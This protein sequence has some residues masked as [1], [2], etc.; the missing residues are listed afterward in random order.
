MNSLNRSVLRRYASTTARAIVYG[1]YG[2]PL[3]CIKVLRH[4]LGE[5][6]KG[7]VQGKL[8]AAPINPADINQIEGVYPS[9][10]ALTTDLGSSEPV[11]VGGNE[12]VFQITKIGPDVANLKLGDWAIPRVSNLGTWRTHG[13]FSEDDLIRVDPYGLTPLQA[14]TVTVNP[15]TAYVMLS[16]FVKLNKGDWFI[17]N[18]GNSG[19][20]RA[21]IQLGRLWG[22]KSISVVRDRDDIEELRKEL[23]S[24]G[25]THVMTEKEIS[26]KAQA[27]SI[28]QWTDGASIQLALNGV[29]GSSVTNI[30]RQLASGGHLVTYGGMSKQPVILP[31]SLFIFKNVTAH[32]FWLTRWIKDN[33]DN[34]EAVVQ[35]VL[36]LYRS[37]AF[38]E[39]RAT[40]REINEADSDD[41]FD[42]K[43]KEAVQDYYEGGKQLVVLRSKER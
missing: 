25:A 22:L 7:Q 16:H 20:G 24:L 29:G 12:G 38:K 42:S 11:A 32:G 27:Q 26:N 9:K 41:E 6:A 8:L 36:Q 14:A 43:F 1:S 3:D 17:Q 21:A 10:P 2:K 34:K 28:R 5:P 23:T 35:A 19:V 39:T 33:Y 18:A 37:N 40:E 15:T 30:A 31:T 4:E 13:N